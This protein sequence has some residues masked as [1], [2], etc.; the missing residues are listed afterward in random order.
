[1]KLGSK[2]SLFS[3]SALMK[4]GGTKSAVKSTPKLITTIAQK[5][6]GKVVPK[7]ATKVGIKWI[8]VVGG[9]LSAGI[10]L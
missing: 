7:V 8:P 9:V 3:I 6:A 4:K 5:G 1:M 2:L 10:N